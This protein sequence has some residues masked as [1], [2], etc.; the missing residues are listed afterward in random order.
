MKTIT[1]MPTLKNPVEYVPAATVPLYRGPGDKVTFLVQVQWPA[2][3]EPP[4]LR[5]PMID[6]AKPEDDF[7]YRCPM[8]QP[9]D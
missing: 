3:L 7:R 5:A 1:I 4:Q 8:H 6:L 2:R 9:V